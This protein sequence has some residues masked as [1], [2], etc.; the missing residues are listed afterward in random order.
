VLL[1]GE[2]VVVVAEVKNGLGEE[3]V[4]RIFTAIGRPLII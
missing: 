2:E 1:E 3:V 4:G